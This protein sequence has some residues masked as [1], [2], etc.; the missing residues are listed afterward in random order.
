MFISPNALLGRPRHLPDW[1]PP[2]RDLTGPRT[3]TARS[4]RNWTS[5]TTKPTARNL[6]DMA[7][8][9][10][11]GRNSWEGDREQLDPRSTAPSLAGRT[12][13]PLLRPSGGRDA[14]SMPGCR[15]YDAGLADPTGP[16]RSGVNGSPRR[17]TA[18]EQRDEHPSRGRSVAAGDLGNSTS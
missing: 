1:F 10:S 12:G 11:D 17:Q 7:R 18:G 16:P 4:L 14:I 5:G 15:L 2:L 13:L 3:A 8:A 6:S 9:V